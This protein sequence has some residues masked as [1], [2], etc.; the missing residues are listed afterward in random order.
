MKDLAGV[1]N[2]DNFWVSPVDLSN[3]AVALLDE[4]TA[5]KIAGTISGEEDWLSHIDL[6]DLCGNV[7]GA[8][9]A[10]GAVK[11][12]AST[13]DAEGAALPTTSKPSSPHWRPC[14][15]FPTDPPRRS[16]RRR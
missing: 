7:E 14:S 5:G 4:V 3:G 16:P 9:V 12:S 1:V 15:A 13:S 8:Q 6:A 11:G 2:T 10:F